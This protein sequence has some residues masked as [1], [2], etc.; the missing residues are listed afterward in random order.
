M[1]TNPPPPINKILLLLSGGK[2][3]AECIYLLKELGFEVIALCISG[4][5][6]IERIGAQK[7]AEKH[8]IPIEIVSVPVFDELTWNPVKLI[9][10][11]LIM[12]AIA[13]YYCKKLKINTIATGVKL[14]DLENPKLF[15]LSYFL[16][17]STYILKSMNLKIM[18]PLNMDSIL[19][20]TGSTK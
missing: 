1:H 18:F 17:F 12:G 5:Q 13:I 14:S 2:D 6:Q 3:S 15:W 10:R 19:K 20:V 4:K 11:D 9:F 7:A 16:K 8:K